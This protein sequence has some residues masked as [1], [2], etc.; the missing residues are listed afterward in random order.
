MKQVVL[1]FLAI[2]TGTLIGSVA[3]M[4]IISFSTTIIPLPKEADNSSIK[5]LEQTIHLFQFKHFMIP[6]LGHAAGS[7]TVGT[8]AAWIA[9]GNK[10]L[11]ALTIGFFFLIGGAM[12]VFQLPSPVWFNVVD[13]TLAYL[14][15]SWIGYRIH[16]IYIKN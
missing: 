11:V 2:F 9:P 12:M 8:I 6:L 3:N 10:L 1:Y 4:L 7:L 16:L 13:L 15:M 5:S 14:L